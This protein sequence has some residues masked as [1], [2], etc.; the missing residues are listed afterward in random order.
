MVNDQTKLKFYYLM[1]VFSLVFS[2]LGFSYN[3]WRM[4]V[5]EDNSNIREAAF[6]V[7]KE[8]GELEQVVYA[9]HYDHDQANGSPRKGWVKVGLVQ[10]L[11][12]LI[13]PAAHASASELKQTWSN[14][15][16]NIEQNQTA[17]DLVV[18]Q[19][20]ATRNQ[21]KQALLALQ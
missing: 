9:L 13:S 18:A 1:A 14:Q 21:I 19:I 11:S 5:S 3:A 10:D 20:E 12:V 16:A 4:E 17:N 15:W 7:L 8:L 6:E 2:L